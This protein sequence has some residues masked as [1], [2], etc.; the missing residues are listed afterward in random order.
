MAA[1]RGRLVGLIALLALSIT[2]AHSVW[3]LCCLFDLDSAAVAHLD[4]V[5]HEAAPH[6]LAPHGAASPEVMPPA[7]ADF[8]PVSSPPSH[9]PTPECPLGQAG[10]PGGCAVMAALPIAAAPAAML[11][12]ELREDIIP[13]ASI[14][15][16]LLGNDLFRPPRA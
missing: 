8:G 16:L 5:P 10:V 7:G 1:F 2:Q 6:D 9:S 4:G 13:T 11:P 12:P 14:P 15:F 3:A